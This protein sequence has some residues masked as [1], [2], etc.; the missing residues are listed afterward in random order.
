MIADDA[1]GGGSDK[2]AGVSA[3][4]R[5][6]QIKIKSLESK[7]RGETAKVRGVSHL[8]RGAEEK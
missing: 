8:A 4:S 2:G 3:R 1:Q 7:N 6:D 5:S